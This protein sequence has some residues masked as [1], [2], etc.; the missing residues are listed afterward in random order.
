MRIFKERA[1]RKR[2][3]NVHANLHCLLA[4]DSKRALKFAQPADAAN[5]NRAGLSSAKAN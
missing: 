2:A 5:T 3:I 4:T 1:K